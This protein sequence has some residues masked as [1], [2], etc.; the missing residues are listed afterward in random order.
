MLLLGQLVILDCIVEVGLNHKLTILVAGCLAVR[1]DG[2]ALSQDINPDAIFV[3]M[4]EVSD[5]I[6]VPLLCSPL[7]MLDCI[8]DFFSSVRILLIK[9]F[10]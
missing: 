6:E 9:Q 5:G 8:F 10:G 7:V 2:V 3:D 1:N 4:T